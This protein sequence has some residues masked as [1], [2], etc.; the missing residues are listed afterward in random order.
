MGPLILR[1]SIV[2]LPSRAS[3]PPIQTDGVREQGDSNLDEAMLAIGPR[4]RD[5]TGDINAAAALVVRDNGR[6]GN[7]GQQEC[8]SSGGDVAPHWIPVIVGS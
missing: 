6:G 8:R 7:P 5:V 2:P 3:D 1:S 4:H